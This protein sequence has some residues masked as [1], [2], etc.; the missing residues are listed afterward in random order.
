[1]GAGKHFRI[2]I[3]RVRKAQSEHI[4]KCCL[5]SDD[6]DDRRSTAYRD[7][8]KWKQ[9]MTTKKLLINHSTVATSTKCVKKGQVPMRCSSAFLEHYTGRRTLSLYISVWHQ[10]CDTIWMIKTIQTIQA[11]SVPNAICIPNKS[12]IWNILRIILQVIT[13]RIK[14]SLVLYASMNPRLLAINSGM[15]DSWEIMKIFCI[16][17]PHANVQTWKRIICAQPKAAKYT[18]LSI[19]TFAQCSRSAA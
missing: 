10:S 2:L 11:R 15:L 9:L 4:S 18:T 6:M 12:S 1:M 5:H 19:Q 14:P 13:S 3:P 16:A 17:V 7:S 8:V